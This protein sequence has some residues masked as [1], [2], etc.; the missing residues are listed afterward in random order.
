MTVEELAK[1]CN[2]KVISGKDGLQNQVNDGYVADLLSDVM[3]NADSGQVWITLQ[4]HKN[5]IAVA[6]LKELAGVILV[7]NQQ[8]D[9][10]AMQQS[11]EDAIPVLS[12][13]KPAFQIT[14]E[15]YNTFKKHNI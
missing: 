15:V 13:E 7:K 2:L 12:T 8:L 1:A 11:N 5:V 14:G 4:T 9:E 6:S 10:D 3:G